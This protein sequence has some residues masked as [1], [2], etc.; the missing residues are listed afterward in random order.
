MDRE[1]NN[2]TAQITQDVK[3][4]IKRDKYNRFKGVS[5]NIQHKR[6]THE[7]D[8]RDGQH[9]RDGQNTT[10]HR[11]DERHRRRTTQETNNRRQTHETDS[12]DETDSIDETDAGDR[13]RRVRLSV[14]I[15][16]GRWDRWRCSGG[17]MNKEI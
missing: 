7:T 2:R 8:T 4:D 16:G 11:R 9:R 17:Y 5:E 10:R 13:H 3:Q 15:R 6:R 14:G 12:T 1:V